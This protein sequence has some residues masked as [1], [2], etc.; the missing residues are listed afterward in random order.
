M[1]GQDMFT[2]KKIWKHSLILILAAVMLFGGV[3]PALAHNDNGKN[4]N[5][6]NKGKNNQTKIEIKIDFNDLKNVEWAR[7]HIAKLAAD[8]I[9]EGYE[10]GTFR[11]NQAV[12]RIEA[13]IAAVRLMGLRD[14]AES[15]TKMDIELNF[16]DANL[17]E[18]KYPNAVGYVA[19]ALEN[20]LFLETETHVQPEVAADRLWA[21]MLLVK[22]MKLEGEAKAKMNV[23]LP[24]KDSK[25][26]PAGAVGYVAIALEKGLISGYTDATFRPNKSVTRAELA[27]LLGRMDDQQPDDGSTPG[28]SVKGTVSAVVYGNALTLNNNGTIT[29]YIVDPNAFIFRNGAKVAISALQVG[30]VIS[31]KSYNQVVIFIEVTKPAVNTTE[32]IVNFSE[33][34][35]YQ[36]HTMNTNGKIATIAISQTVNNQTVVKLFEVSENVTVSPA[37]Q[38][39][40]FDRA[41]VIK[42]TKQG[43]AQTVT[44]IELK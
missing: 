8:R 15:K 38:I 6:S 29:T 37:N 24:F 13:I 31:A 20:D 34:G 9:F 14:A 30:D 10:D 12:K 35:K 42:G 5:N 23:Q 7:K 1:E 21:T 40:I 16:K 41:I 32:P 2:K 11:P 36:Y 17:I 18:K 27:A 28:T 39:L 33:E 3:S 44:A 43:A 4:K 19:L 26:I 22:A 25:D